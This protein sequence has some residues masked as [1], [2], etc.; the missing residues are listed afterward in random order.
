MREVC[1]PLNYSTFYDISCQYKYIILRGFDMNK[2]EKYINI[3]E[4]K[5]DTNYWMLRTKKGAFSMNL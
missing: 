2:L 5:A 1:T 4:I 3:P